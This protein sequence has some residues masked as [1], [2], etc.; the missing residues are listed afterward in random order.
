LEQWGTWVAPEAWN[1]IDFISDLHLQPEEASTYNAWRAFLRGSGS[2]TAQ[3]RGMSD[4][5]VILGD[6]FEVWV[7]DDA[8]DTPNGFWADCAEALAERAR[9]APV[10]FMPGNRDFLLG[11][12]ALHRMGMKVLS[13]PTL[14]VFGQHR[15][16]LSHGDELCVED[17][18]YQAFR[19]QVRLPAWQDN[20]LKQP[21]S[22][23]QAVARDLR[24][25]SQE[26]KRSQ[27]HD[28]ALW[29]DV[30]QGTAAQWLAQT[31]SKH[32]IHG[33]TH[34]PADHGWHDDQ[35]RFLKRSVLSDWDV[36]AQTPRCEV[37]RL[38]R[39]GEHLRWQGQT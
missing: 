26:R 19:Q 29:A 20:F 2:D 3:G 27:A 24:E 17:V 31:Q 11:E 15:W 22:Q 33:H 5:L 7:G 39:N 6:L 35:G 23:R 21:L 30:D 1:S 34:R 38:Q 18:E 9:L 37:F 4:A 14:L 12:H 25:R 8:L 28:P 32:L 36:A 10:F 16:L 13:D